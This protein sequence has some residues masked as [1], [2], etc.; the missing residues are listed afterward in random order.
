[1]YGKAAST[2]T[3]Y[4]TITG[5][6]KHAVGMAADASTATNETTGT[7]T[8]N[9]VNST[10]MFGES[11]AKL[12]NKNTIDGNAVGAVGM[13]VN[14]STAENN[15]GATINL[16][17]N[18]STGIFGK[19]VS[20]VTNAGTID[21]KT[22]VP[23]KIE[24]GLVG[25]ALDASTGTNTSDGIIK[26]GTAYSTGMFGTAGSTATNE[27]SITGDKLKAVGMAGNA[28]TVTN[29]HIITIQQECLE[30]LLQFY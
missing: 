9:G 15:N 4:G 5:N 3:N 23:S 25:I 2:L 8:L 1:M 24:E 12:I 17:A 16:I 6:N 20:T 14:A 27:G 18:N 10:G 19:A 13:A 7:I 29:K 11:A 22:A 26:I 21:M 28:S 30:Q